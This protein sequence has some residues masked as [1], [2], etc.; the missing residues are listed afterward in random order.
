MSLDLK[1]V[2]E[3]S[4]FLSASDVRIGVR[5]ST[6]RQLLLRMSKDASSHIGLS[7]DVLAAE[8]LKRESL[9]STGI[10]DGVAIPHARIEGVK[11]LYGCMVRLDAP[12]D[13]DAIDGQRVD[14]VFLLLLP[15][16]PESRQLIALA[17]IARKL[18]SAPIRLRV[19]DAANAG[20]VYAALIC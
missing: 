16:S 12:L 1:S 7:A 6:K 2:A 5:A 18:R 14:I 19:R 17:S 11:K 4:S 10:G 3:I 9:G 20:D 8:L 15:A 13:F